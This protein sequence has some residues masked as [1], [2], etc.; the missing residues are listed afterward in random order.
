[1]K[2]KISAKCDDRCSVRVVDGDLS[3]NGY[4]PEGLG[5]G[6]GD[7]ITFVIDT[8]TGKIENWKPLTGPEVYDALGD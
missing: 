3:K 8:D 4:V 2:L 5:I 6:G 7:Y 1:M